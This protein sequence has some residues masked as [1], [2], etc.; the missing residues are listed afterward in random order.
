MSV[1]HG[2]VFYGTMV[3]PDSELLCVTTNVIECAWSHFKRTIT[4]I[5]YYVSRKHPQRLVDE[6]IFRYHTRKCSNYE[7]LELLLRSA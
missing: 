4:G 6:F 3:T 2:R 1:D 5:Y 7:R